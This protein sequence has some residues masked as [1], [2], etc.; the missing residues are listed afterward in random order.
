VPFYLKLFK[1]EEDSYSYY[2]LLLGKY[3]T[4]EIE[5]KHGCV[6]LNS[7]SIHLT[8]SL[9]FV[10]SGFN[11]LNVMNDTT[12]FTS[13]RSDIL[14]LDINSLTTKYIKK[15]FSTGAVNGMTA[16]NNEIYLLNYDKPWRIFVC[17]LNGKLLRQWDHH[18]SSSDGNLLTALGGRIVVRNCGKRTVSV[19]TLHGKIIQ[20]ISFNS[21]GDT[22]GICPV[23]A[24]RVAISVNDT[25]SLINISSRQVVWTSAA[26]KEPRSVVCYRDS[27]ILVIGKDGEVSELDCDTGE[28]CTVLY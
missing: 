4:A 19:Y 1:C 7:T 15:A 5:I 12:Y 3:R 24:D 17:D 13:R 16:Y 18:D 14:S 11:H 6:A 25:V 2:F 28:Y 9:Q 26:I 21:D 20:E 8:K 23:R 22:N 10:Q 27:K